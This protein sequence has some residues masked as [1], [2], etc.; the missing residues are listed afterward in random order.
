MRRLLPFLALPLLAGCLS[1]QW[2]AWRAHR[3][4]P[5]AHASL[6][7][8][9]GLGACLDTLGAP[10]LVREH[11]D[12]AVLA[13]GWLDARRWGLSLSV[14]LGDPSGSI[15][16]QRADLGLEGLVLFFDAGWTLTAI[17]S[18]RLAEVLPTEV[19]RVQVVE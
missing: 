17:R 5:E 2:T 6:R 3:E 4:P 9:D 12:G 16:Y 19:R 18:G 13:W 1:G 15:A 10:L 8:G 14:P 11:K 7:P